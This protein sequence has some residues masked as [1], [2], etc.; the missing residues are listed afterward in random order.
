MPLPLMP[1]GVEHFKGVFFR[2]IASGVPL[3]LMP[4]GVEHKP[5]RKGTVGIESAFTFDAC[6][7]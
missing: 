3:P 4:V 1:V 2:Q 6:R 7:R 5:G